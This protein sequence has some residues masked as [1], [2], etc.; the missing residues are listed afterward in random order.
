VYRINFQ[1][2]LFLDSIQEV[3][4]ALAKPFCLLLVPLAEQSWILIRSFLAMLR[5]SVPEMLL[6]FP[7]LSERA[8]GAWE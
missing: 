8:V 7:W 5:G 6:R 2:S 1:H 3:A 4:R